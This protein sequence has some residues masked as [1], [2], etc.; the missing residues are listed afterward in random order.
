[1]MPG[2]ATSREEATRCF[3]K[4]TRLT[5]TST[6]ALMCATTNPDKLQD[7]DAKTTQPVPQRRENA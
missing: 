2:A 7:K 1:M 6:K 4:A 3:E 5:P